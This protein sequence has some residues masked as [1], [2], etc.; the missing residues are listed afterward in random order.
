[1]RVLLR[2]DVEGVGR[3]GDIVEVKG[4]YARNY[5]LPSGAALQ[6]SDA[7][8]S[9]AAAMRRSRDLRDAQDLTAAEVQKTEIERQR[10]A[11][12]ARASAQGRLFGSIGPTE[13]AAAIAAA[14]G[15]E[16][17]R[18]QVELAEHLKELGEATVPV[19]LFGGVI[20]T[21]AIEVTA[22]EVAAKD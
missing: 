18:T 12:P 4:G 6:A 8:E 13:I 19:R 10:I 22:I 2:K 9:Q 1:M 5:L 15:V 16:V 7:V 17:D 3:R 14:T 20:A 11:V 21:A